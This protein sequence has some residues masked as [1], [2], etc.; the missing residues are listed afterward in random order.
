MKKKTVEDLLEYAIQQSIEC[1]KE[2]KPYYNKIVD[3]IQKYIDDEEEEQQDQLTQPDED[4]FADQYD[5]Y[6]EFDENED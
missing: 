4:Y 2:D 5:Y 1:E 3:F 6:N